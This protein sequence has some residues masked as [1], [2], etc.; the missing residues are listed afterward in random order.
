MDYASL[1][2]EVSYVG[3]PNKL[4]IDASALSPVLQTTFFAHC[5]ISTEPFDVAIPSPAACV[6]AAE[7]R[8]PPLAPHPDETVEGESVAKKAKANGG[9]DVPE[10]SRVIECNTQ[11]G[12]QY[13]RK[14]T[15]TAGAIY[16]VY[17]CGIVFYM[18]ELYGSEALKQVLFALRSMLLTAARKGFRIP[19]AAAY[20]DAC[21]LVLFLMRRQGITP[22]AAILTSMDWVIDRFHY[23][24]HT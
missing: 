20:D 14:L 11:K 2:F 16:F 5:E 3:E 9:D 22:A 4:W 21:H 7:F 17:N 18:Q 12:T 15:R 23:D 8:V 24:N 13:E 6:D 19:L 10:I 1:Q